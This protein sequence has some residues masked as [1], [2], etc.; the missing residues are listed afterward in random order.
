MS[1]T[2][3]TA[4]AIVLS[5]CFCQAVTQVWGQYGISIDIDKPDEYDNRVLRS[6]KTDQKKFRFPTRVVQNTTTHYNYFFNAN[7]KLNEILEKAKLSYQYY[8]S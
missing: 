1:F 3:Y 2:R 7:N 4:I 5:V 8:Y 6:E